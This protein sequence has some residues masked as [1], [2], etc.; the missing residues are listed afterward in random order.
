MGTARS[1]P[2]WSR[3]LVGALMLYSGLLCV[4]SLSAFVQ[5]LRQH[6]TLKADDFVLQ[7]L[8]TLFLPALVIGLRKVRLASGLLFAGTA[9]D[10]GLLLSVSNRTGDGTVAAIASSVMFLGCPML[11]AAILFHFL[12]RRPSAATIFKSEI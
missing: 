8:M 2:V 10:V 1:W 3:F 11:G 7:A 6:W 12:S 4:V 5:S 9:I